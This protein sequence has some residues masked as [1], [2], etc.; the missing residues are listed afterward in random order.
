MSPGAAAVSKTKQ[1]FRHSA[2][3]RRFSKAFLRESSA[4]RFRPG[5]DQSRG[6]D[7]NPAKL[8]YQASAQAS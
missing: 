6:L 4:W 5:R 1:P 3:E 7:T 8:A 2:L